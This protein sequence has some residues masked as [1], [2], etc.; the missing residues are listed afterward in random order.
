[1]EKDV[2]PWDMT[3]IDLAAASI[4]ICNRIGIDTANS[5][6]DEEKAIML[7]GIKKLAEEWV[8]SEKDIEALKIY[9]LEKKDDQIRDIN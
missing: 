9:L 7:K 8:L 1:M 2:N 4:E 3:D 5:L 6:N